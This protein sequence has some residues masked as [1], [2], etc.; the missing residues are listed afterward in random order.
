MKLS[1]L[2]P[3]AKSQVTIEYSD[4]HKPIRIDSIVV[5]TQ[6]DDFAS[7]DEMLAK[8]RKDITEILIPRVKDKQ[9][10]AIQEPIHKRK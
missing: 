9:K 8:I 1:Y 2:R 5:S 7:D 3:D 10:K 6:H 4:D